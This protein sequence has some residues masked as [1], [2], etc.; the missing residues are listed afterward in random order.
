[1]LDHVPPDSHQKAI[2][3]LPATRNNLCSKRSTGWDVGFWVSSICAHLWF[4]SSGLR[5]REREP[6]TDSGVQSAKGVR[7]NLPGWARTETAPC[8]SF[9]ESLCLPGEE[10]GWWRTPGLIAKLVGT[11]LAGSVSFRLTWSRSLPAGLKPGKAGAWHC[12]QCQ[13][14]SRRRGVP[15]LR[16]ESNYDRSE[17]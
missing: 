16:V 1:M 15:W 7:G 14:K 12:R 5:Q 10:V 13:S 17:A 4:P 8:E 3:P 9:R 11:W 2:E 6:L